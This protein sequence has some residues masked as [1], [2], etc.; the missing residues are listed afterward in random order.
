MKLEMTK[1][2]MRDDSESVLITGFAHLVFSQVSTRLITFALNLATARLLTVASYGLAS[3]QF[4]LINTAILFLSREG[5][6]RGCLRSQQDAPGGSVHI[7]RLL[8]TAALVM[9]VGVVT[10]VATCGLM[11]RR[12]G[13]AAAGDPYPTAVHMQGAAALLE[14]A[15]EPLY[16]LGAAQLRFRLRVGAEAAATLARGV[17]TL[18]LLARATCAPALALSW[19]QLAY[20]GVTLLAYLTAYAPA[21]AAG[22][23]LLDWRTLRLCASFSVQAAEK[24]V[25]AEGSKLVLV[26]TQ[27]AADQGAYGLA[28][29]LGSLVVRTVFQPFEEAAFLAFSRPGGDGGGAKAGGAAAAAAAAN[30]RLARVLAVAV[31]TVTIVGLF[32]VAFGPAYCQLLLRLAYGERWAAT[33]APAALAAY[34]PYI[35]LLAVNG[36]LEAFVHAVAT[37]H[38][39]GAANVALVAAAGAHMAAVAAAARGGGGA[40]S[41]VAADALGMAARIAYSA[42]ALAARLRGAA[43]AALPG[44]EWAHAGVHV[45]VGMAVLAAAAPAVLHAERELLA[46][47]RVLRSEAG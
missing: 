33:G 24:L 47:L 35:L 38:E 4:H 9:P 8:A 36:I 10:A 34:C 1:P 31:R 21:L 37:P 3:V 5:F 23:T 11:L 14:L 13:P 25:L 22:G 12:H 39:L 41:V 6:R 40:A 32:S 45:G 27:S 42:C 43:D 46:E 19:G 2:E 16:I 44:G 30:A 26:A 20:A 18:A 15:A 17:L 7:P 29:N 28:S